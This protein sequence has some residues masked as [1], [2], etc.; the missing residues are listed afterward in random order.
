MPDKQEKSRELAYAEQA[1]QMDE[2]RKTIQRA[3]RRGFYQG[4]ACSLVGG[5]IGLFLAYWVL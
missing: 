5:I 3:I 1:V 2:L 4:A